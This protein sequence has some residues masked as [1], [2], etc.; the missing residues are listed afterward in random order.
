MGPATAPEFTL[1]VANSNGTAV[2]RVDQNGAVTP[3]ASGFVNAD[4]IRFGPSE[5]RFF[6]PVDA[7]GGNAVLVVSDG[8]PGRVEVV[9]IN[10][11]FFGIQVTGCDP[12]K[13]GD[14]F[15]ISLTVTNNGPVPIRAEIKA[16]FELPDSKKVV[17]AP[18]L[19][20]NK[21]FEANLPQGSST[22]IPDWVSFN[23]PEIPKGRYCYSAVMADPDLFTSWSSA[24]RCF[25][26]V[27]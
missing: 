9:G 10:V 26:V 25:S 8:G 5:S 17:F 7:W 6:P 19:G 11:P 3:F 16:G 15:K 27:P 4:T 1:H 18:V 24:S 14:L 12:C 2:S 23:M 21:F 22:T 13:T 20:D